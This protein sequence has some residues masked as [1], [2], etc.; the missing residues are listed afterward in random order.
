MKLKLSAALA[1]VLLSPFAGTARADTTVL[2]DGTFNN[3]TAAPIFTQATGANISATVCVSC[4][5]PTGPAI[6]GVFDFTSPIIVGPFA[7]ATGMIDNFLTYNPALQGAITSISATADK[8]VTLTGVPPDSGTQ[9]NGFNLLIEQDGKFYRASGSS[10]NFSCPSAGGDCTSGFKAGSAT[11][12]TANSFGLF[13]FTNNTLFPTVHPNF[14]GDA[15]QFGVF[16]SPN[17]GAGQS[18]TAV[19]DNLG[20]TI[21]S[22][23]GPV[24]GA[25]LPG[26]ILAGVGLLGWWRRRQK[27]A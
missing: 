24:V 4:G 22:V 7:S 2:F 19:Y 10:L 8:N 14:A 1:A 25:G 13:D 20:L 9:F 15:I 26:L 21:N 12:L 27:I 3:T 17:I 23:P 18:V 11:G 6:Q 16:F 5:N